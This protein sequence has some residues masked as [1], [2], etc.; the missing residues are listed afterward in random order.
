MKLSC[1][2]DVA[3]LNS[4]ATCDES[5]PENANFVENVVEVSVASSLVKSW[6]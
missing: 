6:N 5:R 1:I 4:M 2:Y 3:L